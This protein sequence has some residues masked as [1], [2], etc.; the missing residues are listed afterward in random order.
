MNTVFVIGGEEQANP[1]GRQTGERNFVR[2]GV[3]HHQQGLGLTIE[4]ARQQL[5]G[6]DRRR[7]PRRRQRHFGARLE[8]GLRACAVAV[9]R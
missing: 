1:D 2:V 8:P 4:A 7:D 6:I 5:L 9:L 3:E